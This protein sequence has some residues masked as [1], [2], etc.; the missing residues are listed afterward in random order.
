MLRDLWNFASAAAVLLQI[1]PKT[2][3]HDYQLCTAGQ[4]RVPISKVV[5]QLSVLGSTLR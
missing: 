2:R 1:D 4:F 5:D 3:L